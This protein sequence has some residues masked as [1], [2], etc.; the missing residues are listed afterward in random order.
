M[1]T[2]RRSFRSPSF[3]IE[4]RWCPRYP[5]DLQ[6]GCDHFFVVPG[7][8]Q[9]MLDPGGR[10]RQDKRGLDGIADVLSLLIRLSEN[11]RRAGTSQNRSAHGIRWL[12]TPSPGFRESIS[13]RPR[14]GNDAIRVLAS[15][16]HAFPRVGQLGEWG[17]DQPQQ[18]DVGELLPGRSPKFWSKP[19]A[20]PDDLAGEWRGSFRWHEWQTSHIPDRTHARWDPEGWG[21]SPAKYPQGGIWLDGAGSIRILL[22]R[23]PQAGVGFR[24]L[25]GASVGSVSGPSPCYFLCSTRKFSASLPPVW[26]LHWVCTN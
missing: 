20:A 12:P 16:S 18:G 19:S 10:R 22:V 26:L 6:S 25:P 13:S 14:I 7:A 3:L 9:E 15:P 1:I 8:A 4:G 5:A 17:S 2:V 21:S 11:F 23:L 24:P